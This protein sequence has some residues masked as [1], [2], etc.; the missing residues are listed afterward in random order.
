MGFIFLAWIGYILLSNYNLDVLIETKQER[1][2][3]RRA[4][5]KIKN[6]KLRKM[7]GLK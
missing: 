1:L 7:F 3:A 5:K 6:D 2:E 4:Y